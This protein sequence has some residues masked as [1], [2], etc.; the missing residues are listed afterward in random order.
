[1]RADSTLLASPIQTSVLNGFRH[2][3]NANIRGCIKIGNGAR[4]LEYPVVGPGRG[5][6]ISL[7]S[8]PSFFFDFDNNPTF[9]K[10]NTTSGKRHWSAC[11]GTIWEY[12]LI[13]YDTGYGMS[14]ILKLKW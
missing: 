8:N 10:D 13:R 1:M 7:Q 6:P 12:T 3:F 14:G 2:M 4:N 5:C 11:Q 9:L